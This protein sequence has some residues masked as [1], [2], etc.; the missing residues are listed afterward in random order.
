MYLTDYERF[1]RTRERRLVSSCACRDAAGNRTDAPRVSTTRLLL[2]FLL[3]DFSP[4]ALHP[5]SP[6]PSRRL[7]RAT[8]VAFALPRLYTTLF[9]PSKGSS[10]TRA[11]PGAFAARYSTRCSVVV[12]APPPFG[13][14]GPGGAADAENLFEYAQHGTTANGR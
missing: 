7:H 6:S 14:P 2:L 5:V 4:R 3:R 1:A 13:R 11:S 8:Q 10:A 12:T 9:F